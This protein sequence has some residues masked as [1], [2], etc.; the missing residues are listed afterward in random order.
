[1]FR[2]VSLAQFGCILLFV[3]SASTLLFVSYMLVAQAFCIVRGQ[4]R[5]EYLMDVQAY[6]IGLWD[7]WKLIMGKQ[8]YFA[9]I[10]PMLPNTL[11]SD[12]ILFRTKE[13]AS[14]KESVKSL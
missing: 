12:G 11:E 7:N 10:S 3:S 8:W 2:A 13:G 6:N 14:I 9:L 5:V 1:M 4:T